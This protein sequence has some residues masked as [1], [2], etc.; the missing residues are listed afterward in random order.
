MLMVLSIPQV[1]FEADMVITSELVRAA[2]ALLRWEQKDLA[3]A[4]GISLPSIK[5]LE[6]QPGPL[7]AQQRTVDA[8]QEAIERAGVEFTNGGQPGVRMRRVRKFVQ[9]DD[10]GRE[11]APVYFA[12]D[13][14]ALPAAQTNTR[15]HEKPFEENSA[16]A[17]D[18]RL[19]PLI[20]RVRQGHLVS[21]ERE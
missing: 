11:L 2:R 14:S 10:F 5:R 16:I 8:I 6:T 3:G 15:W 12:L 1:S 9:I 20:A 7:A 21:L 17:E 13:R 18:P 4:S 19:K